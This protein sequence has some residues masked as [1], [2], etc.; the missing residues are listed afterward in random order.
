MTARRAVQEATRS[1]LL[2]AFAVAGWL[3][4]TGIVTGAPLAWLILGAVFMPTII[5][6]A[7]RWWYTPSRQS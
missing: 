4:V 6:P 1:L 5:Q 7:W 2:V 3:L